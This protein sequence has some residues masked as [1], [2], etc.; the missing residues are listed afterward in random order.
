MDIQGFDL[1]QL[2]VG[3]VNRLRYINR[4][5]TALTLHKENVAEHSFYVVLYSFFIAEWVLQQGVQVCVR[6][7]MV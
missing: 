7:T 2:L 6:T 1:E 5:G 4:F 3:D